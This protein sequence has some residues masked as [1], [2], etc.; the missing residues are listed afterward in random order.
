[1]KWICAACLFC[2]PALLAAE[3]G[4]SI[5]ATP[6]SVP[7][8][9]GFLQVTAEMTNTL[10]ALNATIGS[11]NQA[12]AWFI[13]AEFAAAAKAGNVPEMPCTLSVQTAMAT[14]NRTI[15]AADMAELEQII[16]EQNAE[17]AKKLEQQMPYLAVQ[18]KRSLAGGKDAKLGMDFQGLFPLEPHVQTPRML[19]YSSVVKY[20][21]KDPKSGATNLFSGVVTA[22]LVHARAKLFFLYANGGEQ[23]LEWTRQI[24]K[25]W[26]ETILAANPSDATTAAAETAGPTGFDWKRIQRGALIG[27]AIGGLFGLIGYFFARAKRT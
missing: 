2:V 7:A 8:P 18:V 17:L 23:D 26:A 12:L 11:Q 13:P 22:T 27:G 25:R 14:T 5:G 16:I 19:A 6:I 4:V 1:M 3:I 21:V 9:A 20:A 15:T 24:S 10:Q